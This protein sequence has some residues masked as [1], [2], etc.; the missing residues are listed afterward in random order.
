MTE[1]SS[2]RTVL[3]ACALYCI[4]AYCIAYL[5]TVLHACALLPQ[6]ITKASK[7]GTLFT[8]NWD[9]ESAP[10]LPFPSQWPTPGAPGAGTGG[11]ALPGAP[12][13]SGS[14]GGPGAGAEGTLKKPKRS[15]WEPLPEE[16]A[17]QKGSGQQ[18]QQ[19]Q[20]GFHLPIQVSMVCRGLFAIQYAQ[21]T[22]IIV[23]HLPE[24]S[25]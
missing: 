10:V 12:N 21:Y 16:S 17:Q 6:M 13:G 3:S 11:G 2:P 25:A 24:E 1:P 15:R 22:T 5:C 20:G 19:G 7:D 8:K 9:L 14:G 18:G 23:L 4:P